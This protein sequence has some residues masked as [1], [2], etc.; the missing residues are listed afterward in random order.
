MESE[1]CCESM[2]GLDTSVII[3]KALPISPPPTRSPLS[4]SLALGTNTTTT[5]S[6]M[7]WD[8]STQDKPSHDKSVPKPT[9]S[10]PLKETPP[11]T[12]ASA[13]P[14]D[15]D[16]AATGLDYI[17][18]QTLIYTC[19]DCKYKALKPLRRCL[20]NKHRLTKETGVKRVFSCSSC[21]ASAS[22]LKPVPPSCKTCGNS[23]WKRKISTDQRDTVERQEADMEHKSQVTVP[24]IRKLASGSCLPSNRTS[25]PTLAP[26]STSIP[27]DQGDT[28]KRE[29][30]D[31]MEQFSIP[32]TSKG[33]GS[34]LPSAKRSRPPL[35]S[36]S[37]NTPPPTI[38]KL[39]RRKINSAS[40]PKNP[41]G[42]SMFDKDGNA[43]KFGSSMFV[44]LFASA[45]KISED[46]KR[47]YELEF[48]KLESFVVK[49]YGQ[50][51]WNDILDSKLPS[52]EVSTCVASYIMGRINKCVWR[53]TQ[54]ARHLDTTSLDLVWAKLVSQFKSKTSYDLYSKDFL[55]CREA[56]SK[57]QRDAKLVP[58]LGELA[59]QSVP[60]SRAQI[61]YLLHSDHLCLDT[62]RGLVTLF[63]V[64]VTLYFLPRVGKE[65]KGMT[66][67]CFSKI[68][69]PNGSVKAVVYTPKGTLKRDMG[70]KVGA[71]QAMVLKRPIALPMPSEP[72]LSFDVVLDVLF[73][74]LDLLP[75]AGDRSTQ[76]IFHQ[77]VSPIPRPGSCFFLNK[78]MGNDT[79]NTLLR[80][81]I[82]ATGMSVNKHQLANHSLR[83]TAFQIHK[84]LG[85]ST[86]LIMSM[87]GHA[88]ARTQTV[89]IRKSVD[90]LS[91][92][93]SNMQV[94]YMDTATLLIF[95]QLY[96]SGGSY[97]SSSP[98]ARHL[99]CR[100]DPRAQQHQG[101]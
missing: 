101:G 27:S 83:P 16:E 69:N 15:N 95:N 45:G 32:G 20:K 31:M 19:K 75:H 98:A 79:Y 23:S 43:A 61:S 54:T 81:A 13:G 30:D 42:Y 49:E 4:I 50:Q 71:N 96:L 93:S 53:D 92:A 100:A 12:S 28:V 26:P 72:K 33:S 64:L 94:K 84:S 24:G 38:N 5:P 58:G 39:K 36:P 63:Y 17:T 9:S 78:P 21:H 86:G 8:K 57:Y 47:R 91:G 68:Y 29:Q 6:P 41:L 7:D 60:L 51:K 14:T 62:P 37:T 56:K 77:L 89:Y 99:P 40:P 88:S 1:G 10:I 85:L 35:D 48:A 97:R 46:T 2:S 90:L 52:T 80:Q 25:R 87:A 59:N 3:S 70:D 11:T 34:C 22:T 82:Y 65:T 76:P 73:S 74:H 18:T 55:L 44:N 66:R 67:G